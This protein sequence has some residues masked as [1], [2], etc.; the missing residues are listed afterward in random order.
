[1]LNNTALETLISGNQI[2]VIKVTESEEFKL[3]KDNIGSINTYIE[4]TWQNDES[5]RSLSMLNDKVDLE[6]IIRLTKG[7]RSYTSIDGY[8]RASGE[9]ISS[10]FF[11]NELLNAYKLYIAKYNEK[12][13]ILTLLENMLKE[14]NDIDRGYILEH[15]SNLATY[16]LPIYT[17]IHSYKTF[18]NVLDK[19]N[20]DFILSIS[21]ISLD[22]IHSRSSKYLRDMDLLNR[23]YSL[24]KTDSEIFKLDICRISDKLNRPNEYLYTEKSNTNTYIPNY[25]FQLVENLIYNE[26]EFYIKSV[27][28]NDGVIEF[29]TNKDETISFLEYK[30]L[31]LIELAKYHEYIGKVIETKTKDIKNIGS[32]KI[33]NTNDFITL[34]RKY[35]K[36]E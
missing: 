8:S 10:E 18:V 4:K 14:Y 32:N 24:S 20:Q 15:T 34:L 9:E 31:A 33:E 29:I 5:I 30:E 26:K 27:K 21:Q 16:Q 3:L 36:G 13:T 22:D 19:E 2:N 23:H 25:S 35:R 11:M 12:P 1:M 7:M 6:K 17:L 28:N